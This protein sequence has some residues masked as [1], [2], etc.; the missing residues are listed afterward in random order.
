MPWCDKRYITKYRVRHLPVYRHDRKCALLSL[1]KNINIHSSTNLSQKIGIQVEDRLCRSIMWIVWSSNLFDDK[2]ISFENKGLKGVQA[3]RD[4]H[5]PPRA[6]SHGVFG[7]ATPIPESGRGWR[8]F[9]VMY[10]NELKKR[11]SD[12]SSC[13]TRAGLRETEFRLLRAHGSPEPPDTARA[14]MFPR[15]QVHNIV[16]WCQ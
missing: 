1:R 15:N 6:R 12:S 9:I 3:P 14:Y 2:L 11:E 10:A 8:E 4:L 16:V 5:R 13:D 7:H